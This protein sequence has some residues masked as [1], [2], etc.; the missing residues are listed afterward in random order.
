MSVRGN[1]RWFWSVLWAWL[2]P[3]GVAF[4]SGATRERRLSFVPW[5]VLLL[6][7]ASLA[8]QLSWHTIAPE[9]VARA[10]DLPAPPSVRIL[11]MA[12]LGDHIVLAKF[13]M[14]WLQAFDNQPGISVPFSRLDY[15]RVEAWLGRI[16]ALDPHGQYPLLAAS[17][18]YGTVTVEAKKRRMLEFVYRQ[19][20]EDPNHRWRWL[21]HA[22]IVAKHQLKDLPLARRY[23]R[24]IT[25]RA[26]G[27]SVPYWARDMS[28]A[29]LEDMGELESARILIGGLIAEGT[30][31][32]S[33]ELRFL[34]KK[35][36]ELQAKSDEKSSIR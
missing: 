16:L 3:M 31:Q 6:L 19:F 7:L 33:H 18:L 17:R 22:V 1:T 10:E 20:L 29:V 12:S 14:L 32:D 24:A 25:E 4:I 21:A 27:P 5:P 9:P 30:V 26:S 11:R 28:I 23:A 13:L 35:L 8:A 36:Q 34:E 2:E 15:V